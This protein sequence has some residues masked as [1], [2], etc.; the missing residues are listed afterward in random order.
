MVDSGET[1]FHL[2]VDATLRLS[3]LYVRYFVQIEET[4]QVEGFLRLVVL[5]EARG[6]NKSPNSV[7]NLPIISFK[8]CRRRGCSGR[9]E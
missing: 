7:N 6:V 9:H 5:C 3:H 1:P 2:Y 4:Q 8:R